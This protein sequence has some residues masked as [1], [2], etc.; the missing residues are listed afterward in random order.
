MKR[1]LISAAA[2]ILCLGNAG[3]KVV[4]PQIFSDGMVLQQNSEVRIWG[5]ASGKTVTCTASWMETA[6]TAPVKDNCFEITLS[7]P[8]GSSEKREVTIS[9]SGSEVKLSD[10]LVGE[11]WICSGQSNMEMTVRGYT[12]QPI[13][14]AMQTIAEAGRYSGKVRMF[15]VARTESEKRKFSPKG[16][17]ADATPETVM[18]MSATAWWFARTLADNTGVPVGIISASRSASKIEAWMPESLLKEK[19]GYDTEKINSDTSIRGIHK[20]G[21]Y[22]NGMLAP[23]SGYG[24]RGFLWYQGESNCSNAETY[25]LLMQGMVEDWRSRWNDPEGKMPFIYVQIAPYSHNGSAD[26]FDAP[27]LVEAQLKAL[28]LIPNCAMVSTTDVGE[29]DCI[30][31]S[32]KDVIGQRAA[33]EAL[34]LAYGMKL[35]DAAGIRLR[36]ESTAGNK[37]ILSYD[38]AGYGLLPADGP[39]LGFEVAG[40]DRVFHPAQAAVLAAKNRIMVSSPQVDRPVAVRYAFHNFMESNLSNTLGYPAFPYRSDGWPL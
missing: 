9:D 27:K 25:H 11:V 38:N 15:T 14:G 35:P 2:F 18:D 36:L 7:T 40:E 31:P 13:H 30:H 24:A 16:S 12:R 20:C 3:A 19:F 33:V 8:D 32:R 37:A 1:S 28:E 26:G 22:Y 21:L 34:R 23:V 6:L 10:I 5:H 17:W 4:L 39:V 29:K